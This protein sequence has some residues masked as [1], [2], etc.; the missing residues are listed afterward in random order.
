MRKIIGY[1]ATWICYWIG[2][3]FCRLSY[4]KT[5]NGYY[6][7][8]HQKIGSWICSNYQ[9]F[10]SFSIKI[11]DWASLSSPWTKTDNHGNSNTSSL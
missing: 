8:N 3:A 5:E 7:D 6:F 4:I 1:P 9:R 10:M 2:D 11:Q